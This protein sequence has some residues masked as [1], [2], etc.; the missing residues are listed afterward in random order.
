MKRKSLGQLA[1][2]ACLPSRYKR[3]AHNNYPPV[4]DKV[5]RAV[6]LGLLRREDWYY[7][8]ARK[9]LARSTK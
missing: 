4:W 6:E 8:K 9:A 1:Y 7:S 2:E 5:A 3:K